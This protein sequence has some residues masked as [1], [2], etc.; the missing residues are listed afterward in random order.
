MSFYPSENEVKCILFLVRKIRKEVFQNKKRITLE[1]C[2]DNANEI[3]KF[4]SISNPKLKVSGRTVFELMK[5]EKSPIN[6]SLITLNTLL[7]YAL[8]NPDVDFQQF[9]ASERHEKGEYSTFLKGNEKWIKKFLRLHA[10]AKTPEGEYNFKLPRPSN[11]SKKEAPKIE[12]MSSTK[13]TSNNSKREYPQVKKAST[14][15]ETPNKIFLN[16]GGKMEVIDTKN[17]YKKRKHKIPLEL[18]TIPDIQNSNLVGRHR[19]L[20]EV[21]DKLDTTEQ[22]VLINAMG[23]VGKTTMAKYFIKHFRNDYEYV[24]WIDVK[25]TLKEAIIINTELL[26]SLG[27]IKAAKKIAKGKYWADQLFQL[28]IN[29]MRRLK[30]KTDGKQNLII[31]DNAK[32]DMEHSKILDAISLRPHWKV[33]A[34]SREKLYGMD[35]YQLNPLSPKDAKALFYLH[36]RKERDD[37]VVDRI[38]EIID[39]NTLLIDAI[40]KTSNARRHGLMEVLDGLKKKGLDI[41]KGTKI[42]LAHNHNQR[43]YDVLAYLLDV[44][45]IGELNEQE[46]WLMLQ[47]SVLPST[48]L[49]YDG[50]NGES[51]MSFLSLRDHKERKDLYTDALNELVKYGWLEWDERNDRFRMH[52]FLQEVIRRKLHPNVKS[53]DVLL[54][55][56]NKLLSYHAEK[57]DI[58][59]KFKW[60]PYGDS[61]VEKINEDNLSLSVLKNNMALRYKDQGNYKKADSLLND[62]ISSN[63]RLLKAGHYTLNKYKGNLAMVYIDQ[64]QYSKAKVLLND[65]IKGNT[66]NF[67]KNHERNLDLQVLLFKLMYNI[68]EERD[69]VDLHNEFIQDYIEAFGK[70]SRKVLNVMSNLASAYERLGKYDEAKDIFEEVLE[71]LKQILSINHS[72]VL[73]TKNNLATVFKALGDYDEAI[74]LFDEAR[75]GSELKLGKNHPTTIMYT[76]NLSTA[77][78]EANRLEEA[79]EYSE[80]ALN[81]QIAHSGYKHPDVATRHSNLGIIYRELNLLKEAKLEFQIASAIYEI[82]FG[83]IH[84]RVA[85][86]NA[87]LSTVLNKLNQKSEAIQ[88]LKNSIN[89]LI[90]VYGE[91]HI[92][93]GTRYS[94]LGDI[95]TQK[96]DK[97]L[98]YNKALSI[99]LKHF[100]EHHKWVKI[101]K[102]KL[103]QLN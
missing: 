11:N 73:R 13:E 81:D 92:S 94:D 88:I 60:M 99:Y 53:I 2:N 86:V 83:P 27:L 78:R 16:I 34:T 100:D 1:Y 57:E 40:A 65:A 24:A 89:T 14:A 80:I 43:V 5:Y 50:N 51:L 12:K 17:V 91:H 10:Y 58:I 75:V 55:N 82:V 28:I 37:D 47:F 45:A 44:F 103:R 48:P 33:L 18:N 29:N 35:E 70:E 9:S 6:T 74:Q 95:C 76:A 26:D 22:V 19:E 3:T 59:D 72:E 15:K 4:Y 21:K 62:A 93:L 77:Y 8:Q 63:G 23:G 46:R 84:Q 7:G 42:N 54:N 39:Y 38:L 97:Q 87:L 71:Q 67:E 49:D 61:L 101:V 68:G 90:K 102:D 85:L 69:A 31:I 25:T 20:R 96:K 98:Y 66:Q 30:S 64:G 79:R 36:Y 32:E 56:L 41:P 52:Q